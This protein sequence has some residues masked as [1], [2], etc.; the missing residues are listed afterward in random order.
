MCTELR[1]SI[2]FGRNA[3]FRDLDIWKFYQKFADKSYS[4]S[5][6]NFHKNII[7]SPEPVRYQKNKICDELL[8][9][10]AKI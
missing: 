2:F 5:D 4:D 1:Y 3:G 8:H 6:L 10:L 9:K 7:L